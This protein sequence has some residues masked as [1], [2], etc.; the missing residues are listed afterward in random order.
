[1]KLPPAV[2][3][4]AMRENETGYIM[5]ISGGPAFRAKLEA[6]GLAAGRHI[7]KRSRENSGGPA[8]VEVMGTRLALGRGI[9]SAVKVRVKARKLMLAG[10]P[11]VGKSVVFA[12]LTG[13][14]V[15]SSN[16]PGTT[17][18][19][20]SGQTIIA[21]ERFTVIDVPGAYSRHGTN[22]AEEAA[23]Q[24]LAAE[25]KALVLNVVDATNLERNLFY[26]LEL[27]A[28]GAPMVILLNKW[29]IARRRGVTIDTAAL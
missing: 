26:T 17:V 23:A 10:N 29:D 15:I 16:Y 7:T 3:L 20:T 6:M 1:M 14:D 25:D 24:L 8:Q 5:E 11:N 28:L 12:R 22:K 2:S 13:L 27:T 4:L 18:E 9:A 21:G 19:Y